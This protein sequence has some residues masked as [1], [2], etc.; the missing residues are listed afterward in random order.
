MLTYLKPAVSTRGK[1]YVYL[2]SS[3]DDFY[4]KP[5]LEAG[6]RANLCHMYPTGFQ[7]ILRV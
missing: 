6:D 7:E 1:P 5:H 2:G 4:M 3:V